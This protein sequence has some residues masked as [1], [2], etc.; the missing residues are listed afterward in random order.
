V[1]AALA[2]GKKSGTTLDEQV[3]EN[4]FVLCNFLYL[5]FIFSPAGTSFLGHSPSIFLGRSWISE[6]CWVAVQ[7]APFQRWYHAYFVIQNSTELDPVPVW[8]R[9]QFVLWIQ[10]QESKIGPP[11]EENIKKL[12]RPIFIIALYVIVLWREFNCVKS[13]NA[14]QINPRIAWVI[15]APKVE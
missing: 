8:I 11:H 1:D 10:I 3:I 9:I 14:R 12:W 2:E 13:P 15:Y 5:F 4:F 6:R 7:I